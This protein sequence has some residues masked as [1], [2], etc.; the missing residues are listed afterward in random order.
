MNP[1]PATAGAGHPEGPPAR[2]PGLRCWRLVAGLVATLLVLAALFVTGLRIAIAYL[3]QHADALRAWA[4]QQTHVRLRYTHLDARLRWFGP[5]VVLRGVEV[6][7]EDGSQVMFQAREGSAGLDLWN[8]FRTG[9]FVAGRLRVEQP[10]VTLVRLADGRIRLL[11]LAERP[12][13]R[14]PFDLDRLPAGRVVIEDATVVYR[15]LASGRPPLALRDLDGELRRDRDNVLIEGSATLPDTLDSRAEFDVRLRGSL[16]ERDELDA[17][18]EVRADT[19]RLD[20]LADFVPSRLVTPRSGRGPVRAVVA[21]RQG[22][23]TN[24]R[25]KF[26]WRDVALALPARA[27][28]SVEAVHVSDARLETSPGQFMPHPTVTQE[29]VE[30]AAAPLP[31]E[32]RF[33]VLEG[34]LRLRRDGQQWEFQAEDLRVRAAG[35]ERAREPTRVAGHWWGRPVSRFGLQLQVARADLAQLWP[36]ALAFAPASVDRWAGLAP[37]G[38][39][40]S[41]RATVMR[42]RAG[43]VP[44][45]DL[46]ADVTGIGVAPQGRMPGLSGVTATVEGNSQTGRLRLRAR[47]AAF[48]WPRLFT[49]PLRIVRADADVE[50]RRDGDRWIVA[51]RGARLEHPQARATVAAQ[52]Q[53]AGPGVSPVLALDAQVDEADV[54]AVPLFIPYGRLR[55]RTIGWL[56]RAFIAGTAVDGRLSYRGPVR[57]F[58]FR[59]GE[60]DFTATAQ[61]R[62]VTLDYYPGFAPLTNA[63]GHVTFHNASI[64]AELESG[65]VDGMKLGRTTFS[66]SD[67]KAPVLRI[68]AHGASDLGKALAFVQASPLGLQIGRQFMGLQGSGPAR[69]DVAL[70]LPAMSEETRREFAGEIPPLDYRVRATLDGANVSLPALRA[71]VQRVAGTFELHN[72]Q[73][74]VPAMRGTILDGPFELT[75]VPGRLSRDVTAATDLVARGRAGGARLPAFIGLPSTIRMSGTTDWDLRGRIEQRGAGQWPLVFDVASTLAGLQIDAPRPFAKAG[76]DPRPTKVRIELPGQQVND[77]TIETGSARAKLRFA[78]RN[79]Q[80]RL[81]RGTARFDGQPATLGAQPGLLV[82]G[83]WPQFD[84]GEWLALGGDAAA[85]GTA[86]SPG[87]GR[88]LKDWLGPVDVH[89]DRATVYGFEFRDV[90]AQL[91]GD[92]DAWRIGL[93]GPDAQGQV[94]VPDDLGRGRPIVFDMARLHLASVTADAAPAAAVSTPPPAPTQ[95]D[96]RRV[97]ALSVRANDFVWQARRFGRLEAV[98]ARDPRGLRFDTLRTTASSFGIVGRGSWMVEAGVVRTRLQAQM[99]STD[100]SATTGALGYGNAVD[101]DKAR[102]EADLWWPGGPSGDVMG[103]MNGTLHLAL[104]DGQLRDIKPGAGRMLGLLSVAQLPKRLSLDF[105]DVT[106]KGLAFNSVRGDFEVRAGD[107]YTRNLLL[108]GPVVDIGIVGRTGLTTQDYDQTVIVSGNT[109]G[110]LAVAGALAAGPV[111]GAGVLV[112]SQLFKEQLQGLTR[113]YYHVGGPWTAPVVERIA[114]PPAEDRASAQADAG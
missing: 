96:P 61:A 114:A 3:P 21:L 56:D 23:L 77:V 16:D 63:S 92:A 34:D 74:A 67:Y 9:E 48:E 24:V 58:P 88:T 101:A 59:N 91:R 69:Y 40:E 37:T 87:Q 54:A 55:E 20:G 72:G 12:T 82:T 71:P 109:S 80:W 45:F 42:E 99:D 97:P 43:L 31:R 57:Q 30:R 65:E 17:R 38:R 32:A 108:K 50:W 39:V 68:E 4:E 27:V 51:T 10:R 66:L 1:A 18:L 47:D 102:V 46:R 49:A 53:I 111:V 36:L 81:E 11:G 14:P 83:D 98:I 86:S 64:Q 85:A 75:A 89:L 35:A 100:F 105:R 103:I 13:D 33:V 19:L 25:L 104:T 62:G 60:G 8:F 44:Q 26:A 15:D 112:L 41:L 52:L 22:R 70:V 28:P 113:V 90:V 84:L 95:T 107:A 6:L 73:F 93:S 110:P 29:R 2:R 7:D 94:T 106:D 79:G 76:P 5:E 78:D